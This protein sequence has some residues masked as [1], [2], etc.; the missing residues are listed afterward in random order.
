MVG[1]EQKDF[2]HSK[3]VRNIIISKTQFNLNLGTERGS[4]T[5]PPQATK[6]AVE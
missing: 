6:C 4:G 3:I 5:I 1:G 2:E